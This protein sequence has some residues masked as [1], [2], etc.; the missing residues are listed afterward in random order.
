M[1]ALLASQTV[2]SISRK[3]F[4]KKNMKYLCFAPTLHSKNMR[5][6]PRQLNFLDA[7]KNN[8]VPLYPPQGLS[9]LISCT[10]GFA[11]LTVHDF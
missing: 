11:H 7:D 4:L 8:N 6:D 5:S 9:K 1:L 3:H 2:V 10:R